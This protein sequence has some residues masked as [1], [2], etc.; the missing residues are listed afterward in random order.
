MRFFDLSSYFQYHPQLEQFT[1]LCCKVVS[2]FSPESNNLLSKRASDPE[3]CHRFLIRF[4]CESEWTESK[5]TWRD[6][7]MSKARPSIFSLVSNLH[8]LCIRLEQKRPRLVVAVVC[9]LYDLSLTKL[10][11]YRL[12]NYIFHF[13]S[14]SP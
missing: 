2:W 12:W 9:I 13:H 5:Y 3:F 6:Q 7:V 14:T 11:K 8:L 4:I 10:K 1:W